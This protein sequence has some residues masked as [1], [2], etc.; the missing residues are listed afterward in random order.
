MI[1]DLN[2][3]A[4]EIIKKNEYLAL[5]TTNH[6]GVLGYVYFATLTIRT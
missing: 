4:R 5:A 2:K 6:G 1:K 3:Y